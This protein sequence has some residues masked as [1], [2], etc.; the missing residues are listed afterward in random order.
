VRLAPI[1]AGCARALL[2]GEPELAWEEGF[3]L[4]P[5]LVSLR[6]AI[7]EPD[8][9]VRFGPFFAFMIVR[10]SDGLAVAM[11]ASTARRAPGA[12]SRSATRSS[13]VP[14]A[15]GWRARASRC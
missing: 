13:R 3:P 9:P 4:P 8:G 15:W 14:A 12:R 1:G 10:R 6:R 11:P 2:D 7:D 5:L